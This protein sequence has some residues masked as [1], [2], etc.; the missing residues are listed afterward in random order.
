MTQYIVQ[1]LLQILLIAFLTSIVIFSLLH[2][3]PGD[4]VAALTGPGMDE[5]AKAALAGPGMG[6]INLY[7]YNMFAGWVLFCRGI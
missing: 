7:R 4:P 1:R 2:L 3:A 6:W 5:E